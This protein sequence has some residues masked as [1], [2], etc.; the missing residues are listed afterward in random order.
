M[1][2]P[3]KSQDIADLDTGQVALALTLTRHK[4]ILEETSR[5]PRQTCQI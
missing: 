1:S 5:E 4:G 2:D 3:H